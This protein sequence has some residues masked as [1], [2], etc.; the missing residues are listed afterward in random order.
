MTPTLVEVQELPARFAE[1]LALAAAGTDVIVT[2]GN[3]PR[4]RLV[5]LLAGAG[6]IPGLHQG[7]P[8]G[9]RFRCAP[10]GRFLDG[11]AVKMPLWVWLLANGSA[12][13]VL[14]LLAIDLTRDLRPICIL[15]AVPAEALRAWP[16]SPDFS[17][18]RPVQ[19]RCEL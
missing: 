7:D 6:R 18:D 17:G 11:A 3:V 13:L 15:R 8:D 4:A 10:A 2:E 9:R 16:E 1:L 12:G 19:C 14:V 5:P